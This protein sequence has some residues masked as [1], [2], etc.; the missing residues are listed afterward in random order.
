[1]EKDGKWM[2]TGFDNKK[3]VHA[4]EVNRTYQNRQQAL[5]AAIKMLQENKLKA[6]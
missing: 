2:L 3:P 6:A 5:E 1:V 4:D